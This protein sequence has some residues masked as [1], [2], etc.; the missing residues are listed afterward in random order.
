FEN[1]DITPNLENPLR[2]W[3]RELNQ[4]A[5]HYS[6]EEKILASW[7]I[8]YAVLCSYPALKR[9]TVFA[10][11]AQLLFL[12]I[13]GLDGLGLLSLNLGLLPQQ[14]IY[15]RACDQFKLKDTADLLNSDLTQFL[16]QCLEIHCAALQE[17]NSHLRELY[18]DQ[19]EY[20]DFTPRQRNMVNYFFDEGYKINK[21]ET[22]HLN[23]RQQKIIDLIFENHFSSTKD[24]SLIFRVNRKTIQRD[25]TE[26]LDMGMVRQMGNGAALRY[27]VHIK[28][29][30]H[31]RLEKLQN[32]RLGEVPVQISLFGEP[33]FHKKTPTI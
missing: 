23:E 12:K 3:V 6:G 19:I 18:Q 26:L 2:D 11:F 16:N 17:A 27:T 21:P 25:F 15:K 22:S 5:S 30:P 29:K 32:I 9:Y 28:D 31:A 20:E 13:H 10:R 7:L 4:E 8:H 14:S 1:Q 24:L 33:E